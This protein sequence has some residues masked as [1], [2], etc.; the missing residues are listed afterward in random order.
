M[1]AITY[2]VTPEKEIDGEEIYRDITITEDQSF[3]DLH[4][5]ILDA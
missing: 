1:K 3:E 2:R 5:A 4:Y